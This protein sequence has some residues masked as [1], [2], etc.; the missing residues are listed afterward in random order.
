MTRAERLGESWGRTPLFGGP[1]DGHSRRRDIAE[2][3]VD[4]RARLHNHGGELGRP[5]MQVVALR[6]HNLH[7]VQHLLLKTLIPAEHVC[8][9]DFVHARGLW[10]WGKEIALFLCVNKTTRCLLMGSVSACDVYRTRPLYGLETGS[11]H[12]GVPPRFGL[13]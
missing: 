3:R 8:G 1:T 10:V 5:D 13:T 2:D 11:G 4:E 7:K 12:P 9:R 6:R